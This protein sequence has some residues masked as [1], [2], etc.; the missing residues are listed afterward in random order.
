MPRTATGP[1]RPTLSR[2]GRWPSMGLELVD[3]W[4]LTPAYLVHDPAAPEVLT[5]FPSLLLHRY[6]DASGRVD[7]AGW[8]A[9]DEPELDRY[10]AVVARARPDGWPRDA[11]LAF[12]INAYNACV[13]KKILAKWPVEQV[14]KLPDFFTAKGLA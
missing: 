9:H 6:V 12:W 3:T 4:G 10:L 8:K 7:Y 1:V 13:I 11:R 5:V 2:G 14:S